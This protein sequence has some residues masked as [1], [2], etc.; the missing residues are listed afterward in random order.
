MQRFHIFVHGSFTKPCVRSVDKPREL[1]CTPAFLAVQSMS[2]SG[3]SLL[4]HQVVEC[5][6]RRLQTYQ[7]LCLQGRL[8]GIG[9]VQEL[10]T[11]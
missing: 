9:V 4:G 10:S 1:L 11:R 2:L 6:A 7:N 8:L 3:G 5:P